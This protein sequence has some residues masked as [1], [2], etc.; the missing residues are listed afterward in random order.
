MNFDYT[1]LR[2]FGWQVFEPMVILT[3]GIMF[4]ISLYCFRKLISY[5][6]HYPRQ[7][8]WFIL[9][10]GISGCFGAAAHAVHYQLG[11]GFFNTVFFISNMLSLVSIYFCFRGS[12]TY[13]NIGRHQVSNKAVIGLVMTW[14]G[15]LLV[16]TFLSNKFLLIKIHAGI[17]LIYALA[18]HYL[19]YR[20]NDR[21]SG[22]IALG[23]VISFFS[24]LVHSLKF[25]FD[26]WF[27]YKDIAHVIMII[28][29]III[30]RGIK[31]NAD[32]LQLSGAKT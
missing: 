4:L 6:H 18:V 10:L 26:E 13:F 32:N 21:G 23:I 8:A 20:K 29:M 11:A 17:V 25:S 7:M 30:Y 1:Y 16:I 15:I 5:R 14:I 22:V 2:I 24:I 12:Y 31:I 9:I 27:N 28:S 19:A 3:N